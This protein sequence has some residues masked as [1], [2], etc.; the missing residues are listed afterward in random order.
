[1]QDL[2]LHLAY[3]REILGLEAQSQPIFDDE[4]KASFV[5]LPLESGAL[6]LISPSPTGSSAA[7]ESSL[8]E[9]HLDRRVESPMFVALQAAKSSKL[10]EIFGVKKG[11]TLIPLSITANTWLRIFT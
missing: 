7:S 6:R 8:V 1:M 5:D 9:E 3:Y 10:Y 11:Q 4:L 2:K